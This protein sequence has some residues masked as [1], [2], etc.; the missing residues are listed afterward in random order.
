MSTEKELV[1][2]SLQFNA[3][4]ARLIAYFNGYDLL[5]DATKGLFEV[6]GALELRPS[7]HHDNFDIY[8]SS[9]EAFRTNGKFKD[10]NWDALYSNVMNRFTTVKAKDPESFME[11]AGK[12]TA[13]SARLLVENRVVTTN[14]LFD[15]NPNLVK[16][17]AEHKMIEMPRPQPVQK[18]ALRMMS[19]DR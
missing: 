7:Q 15:A 6:E 1:K 11:R 18:P 2:T 16:L 14:E 4:Y 9:E 5:V 12:L 13:G 19:F 17:M 10:F 8:V 3:D